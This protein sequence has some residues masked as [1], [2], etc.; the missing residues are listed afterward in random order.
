MKF[1]ATIALTV[2]AVLAIEIPEGAELLSG[3]SGKQYVFYRPEAGANR[4]EACAK[5]ITI[6]GSLADVELGADFEFLAKS[7]KGSAWINSFQEKSFDGAC[8]ALFEGGAIA[9]PQGKGDSIQGVLCE[10]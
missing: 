8:F 3:P 5:C 10:L 6:G 9:V 2:A 7:I 1:I 4:A